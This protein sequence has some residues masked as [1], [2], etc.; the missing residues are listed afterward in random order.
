MIVG[1]SGRIE[2][3]NSLRKLVTGFLSAKDLSCQIGLAVYAK[4]TLLMDQN[5]YE[6]P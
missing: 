6:N 4:L 2:N 3:E 1:E 5:I